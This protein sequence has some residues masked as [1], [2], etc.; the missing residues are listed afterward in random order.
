MF[1]LHAHVL[2]G[3]DDGPQ[4]IE[5]AITALDALLVEGVRVVVATPRFDSDHE[6]L[7]AEDV[8]R[9][10]KALR[11]L[12]RRAF[13][14]IRVFPG[15]ELLLDEQAEGWLASGA[16]ATINDGPYV[17]AS[18]PQSLFTQTALALIA[19]LRRA[20]YVPVL[21]E[22]ERNLAVQRDPA[23]A[24]RLIEAGALGQVSTASLVGVHGSAAAATAETLLRH[25]LAHV[26]ASGRR[27][28]GDRPPR[29]AEGL[30]AAEALVGARRVW[31]MTVET[32]HA[33]LRGA[34]VPV[35]AIA[36]RHAWDGDIW[37]RDA[38]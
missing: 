13:L 27:G 2:P 19:R 33:I 30:R 5:E 9:R 22:I 28:D 14:P 26:L 7:T 25:E 20:G 8:Q 3:V 35:R 38:G 37:E 23:L 6:R 21:A 16:A 17:L 15:C 31:E 34:P 10:A 32:P 24:A 18:L 11:R 12:A 1:D 36:H 29:V 4:T